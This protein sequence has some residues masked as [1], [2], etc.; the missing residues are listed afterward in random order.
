MAIVIT[1]ITKNDS[2]NNNKVIVIV[3]KIKIIIIL[4]ITTTIMITVTVKYCLICVVPYLISRQPVLFSFCFV[5][6][7]KHFVLSSPK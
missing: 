2:H 4:T 1:V 3:K 5:S 7:S 6:N